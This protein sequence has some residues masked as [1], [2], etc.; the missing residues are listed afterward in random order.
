MSFS[1]GVVFKQR[2]V[3]YDSED[4]RII[5]NNEGQ[6]TSSFSFGDFNDASSDYSYDDEGYGDAE[7]L[8]GD[9][10]AGLTGDGFSEG[11]GGFAEDLEGYEGFEDDGGAIPVIKSNPAPAPVPQG[12]TLEEIMAEAQADID[13]MKAEAQVEIVQARQNASN[14]GYGEGL[15]MGKA[16]G[17]KQG[18]QEGIANAQ[19]ELDAKMKSLEEEYEALVSKLEPQMVDVITDVYEHV[20]NINLDSL[21]GLV[22]NLALAC[23]Q[24]VEGS[25]TYMVHVSPEDYPFVSMQKNELAEVMGNRNATL[26]IIEDQIM[27]KNSCMIET[28]IGVFDCGLDMQLDG[29]KKELK[30]LSYSK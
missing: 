23:I 19:A 15:E 16:E 28:D 26:D 4:K 27:K 12:P 9:E 30:L 29:L 14:Q 24:K 7:G 8:S 22:M 18:Y 13:R 20:F 3:N 6:Q 25:S 21:K 11:L 17:R 2:F 1:S 5:N 10:L